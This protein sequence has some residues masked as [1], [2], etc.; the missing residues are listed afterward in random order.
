MFSGKLA[1]YFKNKV[2]D[3]EQFKGENHIPLKTPNGIK[4]ASYAGP[5]THIEERIKKGIKP[6]TSTDTAAEA[7]D[8]R[9]LFAKDEKDIRDADNKLIKATK[10]ID[11]GKL[12][13]DSKINTFAVRNAMRAKKFGEDIHIFGRDTFTDTTTPLSISEEDE[14]LLKNE[15]KRLTKLGYGI[16]LDQ[17]M[18]ARDVYGMLDPKVRAFLL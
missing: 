8:L 14:E 12:P 7:H 17:Y 10:K 2:Q 15:L 3:N 4:L 1:T 5:G 9:Y 11:K 6:L 13:K 18:F 16:N